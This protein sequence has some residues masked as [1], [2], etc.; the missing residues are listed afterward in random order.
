MQRDQLH[1]ELHLAR[2]LIEERDAEIQQIRMIN[3]QVGL[4]FRF[5]LTFEFDFQVLILLGTPISFEVYIK[6][7]FTKLR[8]P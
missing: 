1:S 7:S 8:R 5:F 3:D 2:R 4:F 6:G